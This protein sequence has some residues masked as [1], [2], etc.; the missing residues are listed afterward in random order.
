MS[1]D[2]AAEYASARSVLA[3]PVPELEPF[4][5][6]RIRYYDPSFLS[7]DPAFVHAHITLL[8]PW[9]ES[10]SAEDLELVAKIARRT[11]AFGFTLAEVRPT[12]TGAIHLQPDPSEPFAALTDALWSA[13]PDCPPYA[14][15][16]S[17]APHLT[18]DH[19]AGGATVRSSQAALGDLVPV[20]CRADRIS[21]QWYANNGCRTLAEW[22]L[23]R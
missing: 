3:V 8:A 12:P 19:R 17:P 14:G 9:L 23:D 11:R 21:L 10:P 5:V 16:F 1:P 15:E 13:F 4:V 22:R 18:V 7:A 2:P 20:A 6:E